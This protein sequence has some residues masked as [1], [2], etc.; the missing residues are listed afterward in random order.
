MIEL[1]KIKYRGPKK[2]L[3]IDGECGRRFSRIAGRE[4][5]AGRSAHELWHSRQ[6]SLLPAYLSIL[7]HHV[8]K[9]AIRSKLA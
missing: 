2:L 9:C 3:K 1:Q 4:G 7:T 6:A 5:L 8:R